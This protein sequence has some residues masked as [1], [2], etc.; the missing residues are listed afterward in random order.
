[1]SDYKPTNIAPPSCTRIKWQY[2]SQDTKNGTTKTVQGEAATEIP[3]I[4]S[5]R[6]CSCMV[7]TLQCVSKQKDPNDE[8]ITDK[9]CVDTFDDFTCRGVRLD[10]ETPKYGAYAYCR[11]PESN[12]W[13]LNQA[14][15]SSNKT[16]AVCTSNNGT[17]QAPISPDAQSYDCKELL[18][19]I[20]P[21]GTGFVTA[22]PS[23][24]SF[25]ISPNNSGNGLSIDKS[26]LSIGSQVGIGL[27]VSAL[28]IFLVAVAFGLRA[29]RKART[30]S[31][32]TKDLVIPKAELAVDNSTHSPR[33]NG[34]ELDADSTERYELEAELIQEIGGEVVSSEADPDAQIHEKGRVDVRSE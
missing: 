34:I 15:I 14:F 7:E 21:D 18:R 4:A 9:L 12:S 28:I 5:R 2:I 17:L 10:Y 27:G 33:V 20:N 32:E 3:H 29:H 13:V 31:K 30:L 11:T 23:L 1:M 24:Q 25:D 16:P 19:Q 22:T 26:G 8:A 6:L